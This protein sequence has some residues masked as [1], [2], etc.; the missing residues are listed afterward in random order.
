MWTLIRRHS[1]YFALIFLAAALLRLFFIFDMP[2]IVGDS[3]VYGEIAKGLLH[4]HTYG[5]ERFGVYVPTLIR[6]PG[7]PFFIAFSFLLSGVDHYIGALLL[8]LPFD[9]LTC[10]LV[11]DMARRTISESAARWAFALTAF[12]PFLIAYVAAPLTECLEIFCITLATDLALVALERA[13]AAPNAIFST[14]CRGWIFCGLA[15]AAAILLR[16]DGGLLLIALLA[17]LLARAWQATA[18]RRRQWLLAGGLLVAISLAP[19]LPWTIRNWRV[20][21]VFQPLVTMRANDPGEWYPAGWE[22]WIKTWLID[23]SEVEDVSFQV[24]G[25]PIDRADIPARAC[26]S[27][28]QCAQVDKLLAQYNEHCVMTRAMDWQFAELARQNIRL[29]PFRH[30]LLLPLA[31]AADMWLRP[32]TEMLPLDSHFYRVRDDPDNAIECLF[33]AL[34][35]LFYVATAGLFVVQIVCTRV[36]RRRGR[37]EGSSQLVVRHLA[38]LLLYPILRTLFLTT[39]GASEDRYTLECFPFVLALAAGWLSH[40]CRRHDGVPS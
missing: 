33:V 40:R 34:V 23:Y 12:C 7:Y 4:N 30:Y 18:E 25:Y 3:L 19:L 14:Q 39:T 22:H 31:R 29:H 38:L 2:I 8:Q 16:P 10:V 32:R 13:D 26:N 9:L 20:M 15:C 24:P 36:A 6:L 21:H 1:L 5:L 27:S 28:A 35:N 37:A 17:V 11:A